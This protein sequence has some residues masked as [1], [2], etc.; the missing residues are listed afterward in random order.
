M[1]HAIGSAI[2]EIP[3]LG[4]PPC[5]RCNP[6]KKNP[7]TNNPATNRTSYIPLELPSPPAANKDAKKTT[8]KFS[9]VTS[10]N[11][12]KETI[13]DMACLRVL[14]SKRGF[15]RTVPSAHLRGRHADVSMG[16]AHSHHQLTRFLESPWQSYPL[17]SIWQERLCR[18]WRR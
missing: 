10:S 3:M 12:I 4:R 9:P 13:F 17:A 2:A 5:H 7:V 15:R 18:S 6:I 14:T 8:T 11:P 16:S 1:T